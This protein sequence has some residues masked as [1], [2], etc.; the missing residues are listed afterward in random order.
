MTSTLEPPPHVFVIKGDVRRFA[1]DAFMWAS[2]KALRA[3][4]G[5]RNAGDRVEE[6]LDPD[7]RA[8]YQAERRFTLPLKPQE[9]LERDPQIVITAVPYAGVHRAS[10]ILPRVQEFFAVAAKAASERR[11]GPVRGTDS[12]PLLAVPLFGVGGGGGGPVRGEIFR[13][14]YDA[15]REAAN[16]YRV[17]IAIVLRSARDYDL[18][19]A[20][21]R[22][23]SQAWPGLTTDKLKIAAR[24]GS[25]AHDA[26]LVPFMG[27][28]IS[29]SAGAPN[30]AG[31]I[32]SL[33]RAAGLDDAVATELAK[34][35]DVLDQAGYLHR[36][37]DRVFPGDPG[38]F[39]R[40]VIEAVDMRRYGLAPALLAALDSEQAVTLNYDELFE[41][42]AHDGGL[43]RRVI[44]GEA[45]E[46]ERWLLKLHGSV[47]DPE[48]IVLTRDDYLSFNADRAAL[49]SLVKATLMTRRLL[50][51]GFGV[52]DPHFHEIVHD[53]RRALPAAGGPFGTV[54]TVKDVPTTQRLWQ[55][56]LEFV[57]LSNPRMH[58]IFLDALLAHAASTHSYLLASGYAEALP[59]ADAALRAALLAFA[60]DV[61]DEAKS[62]SVWPVIANSLLELGDSTVADLDSAAIVPTRVEAARLDIDEVPEVPGLVAWFSDGECVYLSASGN[63]HH[64]IAE[65]LSTTRDLTR[66]NLRARVAVDVLGLDRARAHSRPNTV[67]QDQADAVAEWLRRCEVGWLVTDRRS[68]AARLRT[69]LLERMRPRF[70]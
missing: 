46:P 59:P 15:C 55:G 28:G 42:A 65:H 67:T 34:N 14:L 1:C 5:W 50:F 43:P 9:G 13:E 33:A 22:S 52:N 35:H 26:R 19:Q 49:T 39:T 44:P 40:R 61:P 23:D 69:Q 53:V 58:D 66:S 57:V 24:L 56:D 29:V 51:T 48:S 37:F 11:T 70:N 27:A 4:G 6:R 17:D 36:E 7:V 3:E 54:L 16:V 62:S 25:E 60:A 20:I 64:R 21:R 30:W 8:D 32:E 45:T 12:L 2:D 18:A 63:L 68:D 47:T 31:L 10:D 41:L 38:A